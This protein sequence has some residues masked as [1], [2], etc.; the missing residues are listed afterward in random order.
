MKPKNNFMEVEP[1]EEGFI[2]T[3]EGHIYKIVAINELM[4]DSGYYVG[5]LIIIQDDFVIK[6]TIKGKP[7]YF[8]NH[9]NILAVANELK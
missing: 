9:E 7:K 6:L 3:S 4:D 8:I 1:L 2:A 5:D